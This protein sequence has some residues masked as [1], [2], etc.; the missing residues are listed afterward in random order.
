MQHRTSTRA[1]LVTGI[2]TA[3]LAACGSSS[4]AS[5]AETVDSVPGTEIA[6]T[7]TPSSEPAPSTTER[8]LRAPSQ[9][10]VDPVTPLPDGHS[11]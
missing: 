6:P 8:P 11:S 10:L 2:L 7:P 1:A 5:E 4:P 9:P 3:S